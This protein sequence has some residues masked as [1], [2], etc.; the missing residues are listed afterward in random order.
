M[1]GRRAVSVLLSAA[2]PLFFCGGCQVTTSALP[3]SLPMPGAGTEKASLQINLSGWLRPARRLMAFD[4]PQQAVR[5]RLLDA[6]GAVRRESELAVGGAPLSL[7]DLSVMPRAIIEVSGLDEIGAP[8][9][10]DVLRAPIVLRPGVNT[11]QLTSASDMGGRLL[12]ALITADLAASTTVIDTV[13]FESVASSVLDWQRTLRAPDV[14]LLSVPAMAAA[15]HAAGT[16]PAVTESFFPAPATIRIMPE[17]WPEGLLANIS[18]S[19]PMTKAVLCDGSALDFSPVPPGEWT[20]RIVPY[21]ESLPTREFTVSL[22]PGQTATRTIDFGAWQPQASLPLPRGSTIYGVYEPPGASDTLVLAGGLTQTFGVPGV[23][24]AQVA[25]SIISIGGGSLLAELPTA[26]YGAASVYYDGNLYWFGGANS[27]SLFSSAGRLNVATGAISSLGTVP[28]VSGLFASVASVIDGVIY[29][30][31]GIRGADSTNLVWGYQV[32]SAAWLPVANLPV[33]PQ[34]LWGLSGAA[35]NGTLYLFGGGTGATGSGQI[36]PQVLAWSPGVDSAFSV[37]SDMP[38]PRR[39][40][41]AVAWNGKIWVIGGVDSRG[42]LSPA[43][44]V[45]DPDSDTWELRP[46]LRRPRVLPAVGV[47]NDILTVAGGVLGDVSDTFAPIDDVETFS[48]E[49][50]ASPAAF[51]LLTGGVP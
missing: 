2:F 12:E 5:V 20:L 32:N 22:V 50:S 11:V 31:G 4:T 25:S 48:P 38:T 42:R 24:G 47:L 13:D 37:M 49:P 3:S 35:V 27:T 33:L 18:L 39:S 17:H 29:L 19:D 43:V 26:R 16:V 7:S 14:G 40:A 51:S 46:P 15:W 6:R 28:G 1:P 10:G 21:D 9:P 34:N 8:I 30:A 41:A 44:E 23:Q 45:Y 36:S